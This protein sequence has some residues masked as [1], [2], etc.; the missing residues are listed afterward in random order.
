MTIQELARISTLFAHG[1][2]QVG[3]M[4]GLAYPLAEAIVLMYLVTLRSLRL[5]L[6]IGVLATR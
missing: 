5:A 6:A 1:C 2:V 3:L 4:T